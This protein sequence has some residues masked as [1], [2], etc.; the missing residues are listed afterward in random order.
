M[1]PTRH[2]S[3]TDA[4]FDLLQ[5]VARDEAA[6]ERYPD[7]TVIVAAESPDASASISQALPEKRPI[8][9]VFADGADFVAR[10]SELKGMA[11]LLILAVSWLVNRT[12][13]DRPTFVPRDWVTDFHAAPSRDPA[14][15]G[16]AFARARSRALRCRGHATA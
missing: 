8:A 10:P 3:G 7:R 9:L 15:V 12:N 6:S 16:S 11:L 1:S 13:R 14:S 2:T 5:R 4:G